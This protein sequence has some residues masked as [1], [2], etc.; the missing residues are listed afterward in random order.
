MTDDKPDP[1]TTDDESIPV[2]PEPKE[3]TPP[4][5]RVVRESVIPEGDKI[6]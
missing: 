1:D 5:E 6:K 4:Q 3:P 2:T